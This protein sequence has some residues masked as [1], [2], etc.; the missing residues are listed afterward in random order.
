IIDAADG[1]ADGQFSGSLQPDGKIAP[2][3]PRARTELDD[4]ADAVDQA[5]SAT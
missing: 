3:K 4:L 5:D 2:D 1:E